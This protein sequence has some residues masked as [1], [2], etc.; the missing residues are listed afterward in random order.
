M[1]YIVLDKTTQF[2]IR[3]RK[4]SLIKYKKDLLNHLESIY[5]NTIITNMRTI[6]VYDYY[7]EDVD[8]SKVD[9]GEIKIN[10]FNGVIGKLED[11]T[12]LYQESKLK[13]YKHYITIFS[14]IKPNCKIDY[15]LGIK[16]K[17]I[18]SEEIDDENSIHSSDFEEK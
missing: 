4:L 13:D 15:D 11:G 2:L 8:R 9:S 10:Y 17:S 14:N 12:P 7:V 5:P 3:N 1:Y 16:Y 18:N 6:Y